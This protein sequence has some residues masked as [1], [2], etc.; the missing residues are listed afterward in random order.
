MCSDG[1]HEQPSKLLAHCPMRGMLLPWVCVTATP[2][3]AL[4]SH[5]PAWR[6]VALPDTYLGAPC[7]PGVE[8]GTAGTGA[9]VEEASRRIMGSEMEHPGTPDMASW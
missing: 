8:P 3:H 4:Y 2:G 7:R 6:Y 5:S 1:A 9:K